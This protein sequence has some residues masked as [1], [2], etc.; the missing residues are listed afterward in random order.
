[1]RAAIPTEVA[2]A[3]SSLY[4][5]LTRAINDLL[6][7]NPGAGIPR[8]TPE[9][10]IARVNRRWYGENAD[11]RSAAS[12]RGCDRCTASGCDAPRQ[13]PDTP[14][15]C[16]RIRSRSAWLA[17]A[18]LAQ[19]CPSPRCEDGQL[20]DGPACPDCQQQAKERREVERITAEAEASMREY[21][22]DQAD[23]RAARAA[24][25]AWREA[26]AA[27]EHR[28]RSRLAEAGAYGVKLDHHVHQHM[29]DWRD[30]H[31][32]P[33][34]ATSYRGAQEAPQQPVQ[35]TFLIPVPSGA[36]GA[37]A[38]PQKAAQRSSKVRPPVETCD[39]CARD[40]RPT[41]PGTPCATCRTEQHAAGG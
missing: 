38:A 13:S 1:M 15:G 25:D 7:G 40:H 23:V 33:G 37:S 10:V 26:E 28:V 24:T 21:V 6:T 36:P 9:Q 34:A 20:I 14:D 39:G 4:P 31:P 8:R 19:D 2:T 32:K 3:G 12:Y 5:G 17:A 29:T 27:E 22:D 35:G 18:I 30:H 16:D 41:T 11:R